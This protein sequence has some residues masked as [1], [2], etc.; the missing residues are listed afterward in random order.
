L[1]TTDVDNHTERNVVKAE[2]F[3]NILG[4]CDDVDWLMSGKNS[5]KFM[6]ADGTLKVYA[7]P[8]RKYFIRSELNKYLTSAE[9][10]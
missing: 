7:N 6:N 8:N 9:G 4:E 2:Q 3:F 5:D 10:V 1:G